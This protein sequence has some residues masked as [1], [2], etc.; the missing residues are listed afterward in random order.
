[1][2]QDHLVQELLDRLLRIGDEHRTA[3]HPADRQ[4]AE[5]PGHVGLLLLGGGGVDEEQADEAQPQ[6]AQPAAG[7][8][9]EGAEG[10]EHEPEEP[11]RPGR[12]HRRGPRVAAPPPQQR[13]QQPAAVERGRRDQVEQGQRDVDDGEVV[14]DG[15]GQSAGAGQPRQDGGRREQRGEDETG[16]RADTGDAEL[17]PRGPRAAAQP[18][19]P[20]EQPQRD[21]LHLDPV[22]PGDQRVGQLVREER[23]EEGR[24]GHQGGGGVGQ[25]AAAGQDQREP[26]QR[27][28]TGDDQHDHQ[29]AGVHAD[30]D[31]GD[32][33]QTE[34]LVHAVLLGRRGCAD[35]WRTT[36][37]RSTDTPV[38]GGGPD[39]TRGGD[40][41]RGAPGRRLPAP[42]RARA[43]VTCWH[44]PAAGSRGARSVARG[45]AGSLLRRGSR[46]RAAARGR[47]R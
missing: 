34:G 6:S 3:H 26:A 45:A 37:S 1:V 16:Q 4:P 7:D 25:A 27:Q 47:R 14:Q 38:P 9:L 10:D 21:A 18:G 30:P 44:G 40:A 23:G 28:A 36:R 20:A 17:R 29:D 5:P 24:R 8:Q 19:D 11:P 13:P 33:A 12:R 46:V 43:V 22:A 2:G 15:H 35:R 41:P 31:A 39:S 32:A 42:R